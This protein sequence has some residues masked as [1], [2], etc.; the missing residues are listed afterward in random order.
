[1]TVTSLHGMKRNYKAFPNK[2]ITVDGETLKPVKE[3]KLKVGIAELAK[4]IK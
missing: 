2:K 1:M 3:K 4:F